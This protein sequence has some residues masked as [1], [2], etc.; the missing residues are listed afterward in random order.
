VATKQAQKSAA[1]K[2]TAIR[3]LRSVGNGRSGP[4]TTDAIAFLKADHREVEKIFRAFEKTGERAYRSRRR[5]VDDM[6][7]SLSQHAAIEEQVFYPAVRSAVPDA[8]GDVLESLEEHHIVKW[9]LSE[10]VNM[11]PTDERF[12]AKVTVLAENVRHHVR[13]EEGEL[14]PE[15][16]SEMGRK[17]L[18]KLGGELQKAKGVAPTRPHPRSHDEPPGNALVGLVAA[19]VDSAINAVKPKA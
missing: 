1:R 7:R 12:E 19:V 11:D 10:L 4:S 6:I 15:V 17:A 13:E 8:K 2:A 5:L 16:R 9:L 14:F 18:V 3:R